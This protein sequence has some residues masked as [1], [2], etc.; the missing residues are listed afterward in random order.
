M[1]ELCEHFVHHGLDGIDYGIKR[2]ILLE[3]FTIVY[4]SVLRNAYTDKTG[5]NIEFASLADD[6]AE[7]TSAVNEVLKNAYGIKENS[8]D[9]EICINTIKR[10]GAIVKQFESEEEY[11]KFI[12]SEKE[13]EEGREQFTLNPIYLIIEQSVKNEQV[14]DLD[15]KEFSNDIINSAATDIEVLTSIVD[16]SAILITGNQLV[17]TGKHNF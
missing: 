17:M 4:M 14:F 16:L 6:E 12:A 9:Q 2:H 5:I 7:L 15:K 13:K 11:E 3:G 10:I 1:A 8:I